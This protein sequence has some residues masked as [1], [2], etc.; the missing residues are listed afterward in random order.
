MRLPAVLFLLLAAACSAEPATMHEVPGHDA[1]P[2]QNAD[3]PIRLSGGGEL[4]ATT[5]SAIVYDRKLAPAGAQASVTTESAGKKTRTSL[6]VEGL[7]PNRRYGA[8]LHTRPCGAKPE[9][10]GP[11]YRHEPHRATATSE[12]W[13]DLT[14][15]ESGAGRSAARHDWH[16]TAGSLPGSLVI[17][18]EPTKS[19]GPDAGAA[20]PRVAC[21][22]L[23]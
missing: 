9:D 3:R 10:A 21:V 15:D 23:R 4:G 22:T 7:L 1:A 6:V 17:H 12:V 2:G 20:G 18:A 11:H 8:H 13:L 16:F 14:T 5:T 19:S